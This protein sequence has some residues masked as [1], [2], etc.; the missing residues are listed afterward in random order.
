MRAPPHERVNVTVGVSP[1]LWEWACYKSKF[2]SLLLSLAF[3]LS[4]LSSFCHGMMR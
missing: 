3:A 4:C 1:V 2:S